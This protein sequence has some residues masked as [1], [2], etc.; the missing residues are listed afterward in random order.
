[1]D[2]TLYTVK[3]N[4]R[5]KLVFI[6]SLDNNSSAMNR[7]PTVCNYKINRGILMAPS[8]LVTIIIITGN[9]NEYTVYLHILGWGS[10]CCWM[11]KMKPL[12]VV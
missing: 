4:Q 10:S 8:A 6:E 7:R 3:V 1:M 12:Y 11:N 2:D 9:I 5:I